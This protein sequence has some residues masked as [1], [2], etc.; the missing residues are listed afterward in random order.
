MRCANCG[1][2]ASWR[3]PDCNRCDKPLHQKNCK[4]KSDSCA[5][6]QV[7]EQIWTRK[8]KATEEKTA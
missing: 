4:G 1:N 7:N 8:K 5:C 6:H 2:Q 3:D